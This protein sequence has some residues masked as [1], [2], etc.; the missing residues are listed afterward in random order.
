MSRR[1]AW[2]NDPWCLRARRA[3]RKREQR[4][5]ARPLD[6]F[7]EPA[8]VARA[9]AGHAARQNLA[10]L[11]HERLEHLDFLVV[12]EVHFLDAEAA[13]LFLAKILAFTSPRRPAASRP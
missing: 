3:A 4:D 5:V 1:R 2:H 7:A 13:N 11:L 10:A 9:R 6:G 12:D 8:L